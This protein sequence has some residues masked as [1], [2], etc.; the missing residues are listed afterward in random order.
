MNF[1]NFFNFQVSRD[2]LTSTILGVPAEAM[3]WDVST[4]IRTVA[5]V[6]VDIRVHE[7]GSTSA[8]FQC[9]ADQDLAVQRLDGCKFMGGTLSFQ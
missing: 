2:H 3:W 5:G 4:L 8:A 7:D 6:D 1:P 9:R